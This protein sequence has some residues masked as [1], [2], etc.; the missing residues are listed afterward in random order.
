MTIQGFNSCRCK[1]LL[2]NVLKTYQDGYHITMTSRVNKERVLSSYPDIKLSYEKIS[3]KKV[4]GADIILAIPVGKRCIVWFTSQNNQRVCYLL[5]LGRNRQIEDVQLY[6][7]CFHKDLGYGS[8]FYGTLFHYNQTPFVAIE[9]VYMYKG[10]KIGHGPYGE[11]LT[12]LQHIFMKEL[13]QKSPGR[14]F[15][16]FGLP[17]FHNNHDE[18]LKMIS[19]KQRI[20]CFQYRY[21]HNN[22]ILFAKPVTIFNSPRETDEEIQNKQPPPPT[23]PVIKHTQQKTFVERAPIEKIFIVTP[24]IQND[25]YHLHDQKDNYIGMACIPDYI[26]SVMMNKLFRNIKENN[27]LDTL[28]ESDDE[29]EFECEDIDKFVH[30]DKQYKMKCKFNKKFKMWMPTEVC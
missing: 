24:D 7:A 16:S 29:D 11:K 15:V 12:L 22:N 1:L 8:I 30:L 25:I 13:P 10:R 19:P 3:H 9:D 17:L 14:H 6:P 28:E 2:L 4:Q 27:N 18:L 23:K 21:L 26:T 5:T 20:M